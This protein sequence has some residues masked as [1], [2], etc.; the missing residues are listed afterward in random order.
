MSL[1]FQSVIAYFLYLNNLEAIKR[2]FVMNVIFIYVFG[3]K[4]SFRFLKGNI[5]AFYK[6]KRDIKKVVLTFGL[7]LNQ[8]KWFL[9]RRYSFILKRKVNILKYSSK[10]LVLLNKYS[11]LKCLL[12]RLFLFNFFLAQNKE[13]GIY[14]HLFISFK[15]LYLLKTTKKLKFRKTVDLKRKR[16]CPFRISPL[17]KVKKNLKKKFIVLRKK[18]KNVILRRII[19]FN[20]NNIFT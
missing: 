18:N 8:L 4:A 15:S 12:Y 10:M 9:S 6:Q 7:S 11:V 20:L 13:N 2:K 19:L 1:N 14:A 5:L 17:I 16:L 3:Q